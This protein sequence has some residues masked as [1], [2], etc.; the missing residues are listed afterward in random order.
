VEGG[1]RQGAALVGGLAEHTDGLRLAVSDNR[2]VRRRG[3]AA[4]F[5]PV[6]TNPAGLVRI[7]RAVGRRP[8]RRVRLEG[9]RK[10]K[11]GRAKPDSSDGLILRISSEE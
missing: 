2:Q 9:A 8:S 6:S 10:T 1:R 11:K 4:R 7:F 3:F 5:L